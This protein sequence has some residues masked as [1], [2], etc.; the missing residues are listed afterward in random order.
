ML[1]VSQDGRSYM[2]LAGFHQTFS[3][4]VAK[5]RLKAGGGRGRANLPEQRDKITN[6]VVLK[7]N[8]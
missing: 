7:I 1:A 4:I 6:H 3:D 8:L 5:S 2:A